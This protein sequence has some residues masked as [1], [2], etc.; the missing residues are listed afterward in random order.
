MRPYK[1]PIH[2][3]KCN[4]KYHLDCG[5]KF[6]NGKYRHV[7]CSEHGDYTFG[8]SAFELRMVALPLGFNRYDNVRSV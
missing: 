5:C 6:F 2:K 1:Q 3:C 4:P 7:K 8:T